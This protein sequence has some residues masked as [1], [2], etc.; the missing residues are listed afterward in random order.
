MRKINIVCGANYGDEGKGLVTNALA[1]WDNGKGTLVVFTSNSAQR[2][3]TVVRKGIRHAFRCFGSAT[4]KGAATYYAAGYMPNPALFREEYEK[5]AVLGIYPKV[6]ISPQCLWVTPMDMYYNIIKSRGKTNTTGCGAWATI[7]RDNYFE[8]FEIGGYSGLVG[9]A[10]R[11]MSILK[12][13]LD[14]IKDLYSKK[15]YEDMDIWF[16]KGDRLIA[17]IMEDFYFMMS[18][19][20]MIE[21]KKER[22]FLHSFNHLIFENSQGLL[23]DE[24]YSGQE[25]TTPAAVGAQKPCE[26]IYKNFF[27]EMVK[28]NTYYVSRTFLTRHGDGPLDGIEFSPIDLFED[29]TNVPNDFQGTLRY[30][31]FTDDALNRLRNRVM[32]DTQD[33]KDSMNIDI[34]PNFVFTFYNQANKKIVKFIDT[35]TFADVYVSHSEDTN[36]LQPLRIN[37]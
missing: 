27:D 11:D 18:H 12:S 35:L 37:F 3:H 7:C 26:L 9:D 8:Q 36:S 29:R 21:T 15:V 16:Y 33:I 19:C 34:H 24:K 22:E 5:L 14:F 23:L 6:Y 1:D 2:S 17:N 31:Y 10:A 30:S 32:Q 25:F 28:I 4:L 13:D 20:E